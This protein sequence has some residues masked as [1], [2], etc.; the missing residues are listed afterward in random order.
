MIKVKGANQRCFHLAQVLPLIFQ[1]LQLVFQNRLGAQR[2]F[3]QFV[4]SRS[5]Q[6]EVDMNAVSLN[7]TLEVDMDA[8]NLW[9]Y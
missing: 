6:I 9:I 7:S 8:V 2:I 1:V 4:G 3:K 5:T